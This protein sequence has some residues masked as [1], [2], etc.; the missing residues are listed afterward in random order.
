M[1]A[2][3]KRGH[4][5][6]L[7][8]RFPHTI[9]ARMIFCTKNY[10]FQR[11]KKW[12]RIQNH[13]FSSWARKNCDTPDDE[14]DCRGN[15]VPWPSRDIWLRTSS[16]LSSL[17]PWHMLISVFLLTLPICS[18]WWP[19]DLFFS[20]MAQNPIPVFILA[21]GSWHPYWGNLNPLGNFLEFMWN[22]LL[23][24]NTSFFFLV[25]RRFLLTDPV[26][27]LTED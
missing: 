19:M 10:N 22:F 4:E 2:P 3:V 8:D 24:E 13:L 25:L 15:D 6:D 27:S 14:R 21:L 18:L 12:A 9:E 17:W 20:A 1:L 16:A 11:K 26:N 5:N 23:H 7:A